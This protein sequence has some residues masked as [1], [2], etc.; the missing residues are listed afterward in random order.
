MSETTTVEGDL[1]VRDARIAL[2]VSRF[3]SFVVESLLEGA[4]DTLKRHGADERDLQIRPSQGSRSRE[5]AEPAPDDDHA[6]ALVEGAAD[7]QGVV[8]AAQHVQPFER[9][10]AAEGAGCGAGRFIV[11]DPVPMAL[12]ATAV[13]G[14][15]SL[16]IH[17]TSL[18]KS[19]PIPVL[20]FRLL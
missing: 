15:G 18:P 10:D 11:I 2:L 5:T 7:R 16:V 4:L 19:A 17:L 14:A 20:L 9:R 13:S 8:Q 6:R 1:V 12:L 3:N